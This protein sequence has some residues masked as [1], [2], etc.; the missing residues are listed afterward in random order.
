[1]NAPCSIRPIIKTITN[2]AVS[3]HDL[4]PL[5]RGHGEEG[6]Q[7]GSKRLRVAEPDPSWVVESST[8]QDSPPEDQPPDQPVVDAEPHDNP[9]DGDIVQPPEP[10][11]PP[12]PSVEEYIEHSFTHYPTKVW[13]PVCIK[14]SA[15]NH[16]HRKLDH[17][18]QT[19]VISGDYMYMMK[20]PDDEQLV[21]PIL[22][23]KAKISGGVW[24]LPVT[25]KGTYL[26]NVAERVARIINSIGA[27]K[28]IFKTDQEP[29]IVSIQKEVRKELW[30]EVIEIM[31]RVKDLGTTSEEVESSPG[32]VVILENSPVGESQSNVCLQDTCPTLSCHRFARFSP[33]A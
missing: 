32:G 16:P 19:E 17:V 24:A 10:N 22:V 26:N 30:K 13:C 20:Q 2:S 11:V 7:S 23:L 33:R 9:D 28:I 25:R 3:P 8:P 18:R 4:N 27:P 12:I 21:H 31:N 1:M 29:A 5:P 15:Q 6:E 14:N